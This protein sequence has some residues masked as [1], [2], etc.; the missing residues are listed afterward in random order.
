MISKAI[1]MF[2]LCYIFRL[3]YQIMILISKYVLCD[4]IL[5]GIISLAIKEEK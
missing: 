3:K 4:V 2:M 5:F 1:F